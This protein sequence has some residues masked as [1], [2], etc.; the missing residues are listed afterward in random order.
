[1]NTQ[2]ST[3][4][5]EG[6]YQRELK[7]HAEALAGALELC[8][9]VMERVYGMTLPVQKGTFSEEQDWNKAV[10]EARATLT[11]WKVAKREIAAS[12]PTRQESNTATP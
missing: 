4:L 2:L 7:S 6:N 1:M 3:M 5:I 8:R 12:N 11:A 9:D 10:R